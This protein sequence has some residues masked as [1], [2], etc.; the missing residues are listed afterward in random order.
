MSIVVK[1]TDSSE[2]ISEFNQN[3]R[4]FKTLRKEQQKEARELNEKIKSEYFEEKSEADTEHYYKNFEKYI[5]KDIPITSTNVSLAEIDLTAVEQFM[6]K[7]ALE[8]DL[9]CMLEYF[10]DAKFSKKDVDK[11]LLDLE[12]VDEESSELSLDGFFKSKQLSIPQIYLVLAYLFDKLRQ[13]RKRRLLNL[14]KDLLSNL[15]QQNSSLLFEFFELA[16]H[17]SIHGNLKLANQLANLSS[18]EVKLATIKQVL[19]FIKDTLDNEFE[20]LVS[21]CLR[22]RSQ[23]LNNLKLN[24]NNFENLTELSLYLKLEK[25]LAII[26]S[27]FLKVKNFNQ[28]IESNKLLEIDKI[29][30]DYQKSIGGIVNFAELGFVSE[31][32]VNN[33]IAQLGIEIDLT[34]KPGFLNQLVLLFSGL[35]LAIFNDTNAQHQKVID[36]IRACFKQLSPKEETRKFDFI[37][38]QKFSIEYV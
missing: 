9:D 17:P 36:G 32:A 29:A 15:E 35:P 11:L 4:V 37:K 25:N 22:Y 21:N 12:G 18:G 16:K 8:L 34:T 23:I 2:K 27:I 26:Q 38:P 6:A 1:P 20:N 14:L 7:Y 3:R 30:A 33:L 13:S 10:D 31:S 5:H 19:G 28:K 24:Q